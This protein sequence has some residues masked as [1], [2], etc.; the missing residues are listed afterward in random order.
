MD[1]FGARSVALLGMGIM[2]VPVV[3]SLT[4]ILKNRKA[5]A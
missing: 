5:K 4:V 1:A 3:I 2:L